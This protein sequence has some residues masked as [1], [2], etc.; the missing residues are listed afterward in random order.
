M[1]YYDEI[2]EGYDELHGEEQARK[3]ELILKNLEIRQNDL[4]LDVGC[5]TGL[6]GKFIDARIIGVD[7]TV[8]L[9]KTAQTRLYNVTL[10]GAENLPFNSKVFDYVFSLTAVH[11]FRDHEMGLREIYRVVG[12]T[13]VISILKRAKDYNG[14]IYS[15]KE[16]YKN[17]DMQI[18]DDDPHD[19]IFILNR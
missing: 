12:K 11:N 1:G 2:A 17:W 5:G 14:I 15:V 13:A 19:I 3:Y 18:I 16:I 6:S 10:C 9:L 8:Q 7:P 4:V